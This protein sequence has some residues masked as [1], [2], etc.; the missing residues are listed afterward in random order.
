[1][2]Q[3]NFWSR[4][5]VFQKSLLNSSIGGLPKK[6]L[7]YLND[8]DF[9]THVNMKSAYSDKY[10]E[11]IYFNAHDAHTGS[12]AATFSIRYSVIVLEKVAYIAVEKEE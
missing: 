3:E 11:H 4:V 8:K 7:D 2:R 9:D 5:F 12:R 10:K 1:M 6:P